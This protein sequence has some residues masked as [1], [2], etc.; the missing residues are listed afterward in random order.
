MH[1]S[2]VVFLLYLLAGVMTFAA[3]AN[4]ERLVD[5]GVVAPML[6]A[7]HEHAGNADLTRATCYA[8]HNLSCAGA[9]LWRRGS[10]C[11]DV[12]QHVLAVFATDVMLWLRTAPMRACFHRSWRR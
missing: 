7:M 10:V 4:V 2:N 6:A 9:C 5:A 8:I 11:H 1:C 12:M 3:A